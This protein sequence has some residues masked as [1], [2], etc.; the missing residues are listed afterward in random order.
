ML[1]LTGSEMREADRHSIE[2]LG[3][4]SLSLMENAGQAVARAM[5][6]EIPDL[7]KRRV[8]VICGK[9]NN[10]GDGLVVLRFLASQGVSARAWLLCS[11]ED[12]SGDARHNLDAALEAKLPVVA[13]PDE[14]SWHQALSEVSKANVIVDAI[15]GTGLTRPATGLLEQAIR[16]IN[17]LSAF[18]VAVDVPSGL[19][20]D[21]GEIRGLSIEADLTVALAAPKVCHL[22]APAC[23]RSSRLEVVD[24]GIPKAVLEN[25]GGRIQT[26]EPDDVRTR[27]PH[28][29]AE[30]HKGD[31]GHLL[32]VGGSVSKP[33]AAVMA[34][35][36]AL[37]A[38]VGLVTVAAPRGALALMAPALQEAMWEPLDQ[39][40]DGGIAASAHGRV[41]ELLA[42]KTSMA[43]GPGLGQNPETVGLVKRLVAENELPIVIDADGLNAYREDVGALPPQRPLALTPHPGEASRLL[44]CTARDIQKNRLESVRKLAGETST[45]VLLKGYR[46]LVCD[47]PGNVFINL[48]GNPGLATGGSGDVL[49]GMV[50]AL[51][52]RLP[53]DVALRVAAYL[54]GLAADVAVEEIGQTSLIATDVI[55]YLPKAL[56]RLGAG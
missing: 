8:A 33:G 39:T 41:Q 31:F 9:G 18:K 42:G 19:S 53:V 2:D 56:R 23:L 54:H 3:I 25:V 17:E 16:D 14:S 52:N 46:S 50:G 37:R 40:T 38:G 6:Q 24:I 7:R 32:I 35:R 4:P 44:A 20:S 27:L 26:I 15:F 43:I 12:L 11:F 10:G 22:V 5:A 28:R 29:K 47:P 48:T 51:I 45:F 13:A 34:A 36:A 49:T 1:V 30:A 55:Q 21:T